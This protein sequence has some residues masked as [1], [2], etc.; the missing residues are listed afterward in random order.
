MPTGYTAKLMEKGEDFDQFV[1]RCARAFGACIM[2]RDDSMDTPIPEAFEPS[3]YH[4]KA[5]QEAQKQYN[6]LIAM[7]A[8]EKIAFGKKAKGAEVYSAEKYLEKTLIENSRLWAMSVKVKRWNP[9]TPDHEGLKKF[10][11]QQLDVSK[12][13]TDYCNKSLCEAKN[14]TPLAYY[15]EAVAEAERGIVYHAEGN[16]KE[17]ER[18]SGRT[19]WIK[20]LRESLK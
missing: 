14:K 1:L 13:S 16:K 10:M 17:I 5:I 3:D 7:T 12:S 19:E 2:M 11:L 6:D 4:V 9:P 20:Q 15:A 8:E 18:A